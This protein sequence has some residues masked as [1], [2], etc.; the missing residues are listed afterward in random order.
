MKY[1]VWF[2]ITVVC[3]TGGAFAGLY[4]AD[5]VAAN[6][7]ADMTGITLKEFDKAYAGCVIENGELCNLYGGF[8]PISKFR[9]GRDGQPPKDM[10]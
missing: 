4:Y 2:I 6:K 9:D 10:L 5:N 1:F 8:A 7:F 3:L